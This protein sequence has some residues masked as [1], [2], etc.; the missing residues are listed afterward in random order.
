[1]V[2]APCCLLWPIAQHSRAGSRQ[3]DVRTAKLSVYCSDFP[4]KIASV[5]ADTGEF[6]EERLAHPEAAVA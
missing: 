3:L 5:D 2:Y 1:M 6:R 4:N